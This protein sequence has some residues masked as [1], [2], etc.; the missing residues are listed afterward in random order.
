MQHR[1][2]CL[3]MMRQRRLLALLTQKWVVIRLISIERGY[4]PKQFAMMP[5]GGGGALHTGAMMRDIGLSASIVPRYPGVNLC[6]CV[7]CLTFVMMR[8]AH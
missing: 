4:D 2:T 7:S 3:C 6:S 1:L 8:C 5:F